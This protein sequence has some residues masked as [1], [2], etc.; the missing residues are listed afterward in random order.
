MTVQ[1]AKYHKSR[2]IIVVFRARQLQTTSV[3]RED[4]E[5]SNL[6]GDKEVKAYKKSNAIY[7]DSP[8]DSLAFGK[9]LYLTRNI[10]AISKRVCEL[11][12]LMGIGNANYD[13]T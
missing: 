7:S 6:S 4:A 11:I 8:E 10:Y 9:V 2:Q 13:A 3:S 1:T 5:I 12:N